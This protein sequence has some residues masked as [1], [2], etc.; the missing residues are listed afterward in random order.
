MTTVVD[1]L[2]DWSLS[3]FSLS[4]SPTLSHSLKRR[5]DAF[6]DRKKKKAPPKTISAVLHTTRLPSLFLLKNKKRKKHKPTQKQKEVLFS[7]EVHLTCLIHCSPA[8]IFHLPKG[9]ELAYFCL[10]DL[11]GKLGF[12]FCVEG[13][14]WEE[15]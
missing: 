10:W 12:L 15:K 9:G 13:E 14:M 2:T 5:A 1:W 4:L 8:R 6:P 3:L 11:K 7:S